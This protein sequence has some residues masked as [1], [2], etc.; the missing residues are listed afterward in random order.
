MLACVLLLTA[1]V[2]NTYGDRSPVWFADAVPPE[3]TRL[4]RHASGTMAP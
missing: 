1:S 2:Q 4:L 3:V